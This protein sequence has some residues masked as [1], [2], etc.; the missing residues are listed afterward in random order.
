[1]TGTVSGWSLERRLRKR[2]AIVTLLVTLLT[3]A[4]VGI[5]YGSDVSDLRQRKVL[6]RAES[7]AA[8]LAEMPVETIGADTRSDMFGQFFV[9]Y[10]QAYGWR[11]LGPN[12]AIVATSEF[13]W[14]ELVTM[15]PSSADEWTHRVSEKGW[16][17][18]KHFA[19]GASRCEVQVIALSDPAHLLSWLIAGEIGV[20]ILLPILPFGLLMLLA[21]RRVIHSTL[22]PLQ[23]MSER[24]NAIQ[25]LHDVEPIEVDD[26]PLE[27]SGLATALN[28][29][30]QRLQSAMEREQ[31]FILDAAHTLRTPLAALGSRLELDGAD[32]DP[33]VL[34]EDVDALT[35][36]CSQLLTAAHADRLVINPHR[37]IDAGTLIMDTIARLDRLAQKS[38]VELAY[39]CHSAKTLIQ[40]DEDALA[41]ALTNLIENAIQHAPKGSEILVSLHDAPLRVT[42]S[43]QGPGLADNQIEMLVS[44]FARGRGARDG[45][46]GLGLSIV[47]RIMDVHGGHLRF[48]TPEKG[49]LAVSL[50]FESD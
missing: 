33:K 26:A 14:A 34:R 13:N 8:S 32:V 49:G 38:G 35:R 46:A 17:A 29:A 36:L 7:I 42:V 23:H 43:D 28:E 3:S 10:S 5:H 2:L 30:H 18:G 27:V 44:R 45:G 12:G 24:A 4:I 37:R 40:G 20:H 31:A 11:I 9:T 6:E 22:S 50:V 39:V 15:P 41:I 21:S 25:G 48:Q 19:C 16:I 1:M 47:S